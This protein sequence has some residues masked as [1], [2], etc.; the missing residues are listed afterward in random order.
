MEFTTCL[1]L[2]FQATRLSR[3]TDVENRGNDPTGLTPSMASGIAIDKHFG[4]DRLPHDYSI[5]G[6]A[7]RTFRPCSLRAELLPFQSPLLRES[8]LV[9]FPPRTYMLKLCGYSLLKQGRFRHNS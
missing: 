9:S 2:H 4:S 1:G 7:H 6:I 8:L 5:R 3:A